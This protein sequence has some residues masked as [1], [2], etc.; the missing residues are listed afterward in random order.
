[1]D[2]T[3]SLAEVD[4]TVCFRFLRLAGCAAALT[5]CSQA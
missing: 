2:T 3:R 5:G 4:P 1:M